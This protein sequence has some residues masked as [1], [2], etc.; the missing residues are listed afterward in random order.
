MIGIFN[1]V[2]STITCFVFAKL[3]FIDFGWEEVPHIY[4]ITCLVA[5]M[6]SNRHTNEFQGVESISDRL[7]RQG[8]TLRQLAMIGLPAIITSGLLIFPVLILITFFDR[9]GL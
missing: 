2:W 7:A 8:R 4:P 1:R 9:S 5:L 6:F 3:M